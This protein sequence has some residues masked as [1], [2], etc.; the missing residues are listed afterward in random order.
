MELSFEE[1]KALVEQSPIIIWRSD[2]SGACDYF[3]E[4]WLAFTGRTMEQELG[5]GWAEGVMPSDLEACMATY[6]GSFAKR[7]A[8]EMKY[9]LKRHDGQY[10]WILDRGVPFHSDQGEFLGYI[11][12]CIDITDQVTADE[13]LVKQRDRELEELRG[14]L[15]IC[16]YC[17]SIR[18]D[19]GNWHKLESYIKIHSHTDFTHGICPECR[20]KIK[21]G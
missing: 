11:G 1:Y 20:K 2:T 16:A 13:Y 3:N 15:P 19:Q 14:L 6:V 12:S 10:R 9:R 17:K 8:F 4:R 18:D 5:A 7:E 21:I